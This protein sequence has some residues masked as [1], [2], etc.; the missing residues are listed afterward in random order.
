MCEVSVTPVL[1][2]SG[3]LFLVQVDLTEQR[4][5]EAWK[6]LIENQMRRAQKLEA[7]GM[8]RCSAPLLFLAPGSP[9][10]PG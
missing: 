1:L 9:S 2:S 10:A 7:L 4:R 3:E 5:A 8:L 6:N